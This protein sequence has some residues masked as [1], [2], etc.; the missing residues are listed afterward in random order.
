MYKPSPHPLYR[1]MLLYGKAFRML[2]RR[3]NCLWKLS[4]TFSPIE[5]SF[6]RISI[7]FSHHI[8]FTG[9]SFEEPQSGLQTALKKLVYLQP[10]A[11]SL[12]SL[13]STPNT[14]FLTFAPLS[15]IALF[16]EM[17]CLNS[18]GLQCSGSRT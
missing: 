18:Q 16:T 2:Q 6:C 11:L 1:Y 4:S 3:G 7:N 14:I 5:K 12:C 15:A 17:K 13:A 9:G 8:Y 10:K